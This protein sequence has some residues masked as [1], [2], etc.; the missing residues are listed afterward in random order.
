MRGETRGWT[1]SGQSERG[2]W[3]RAAGALACL[4][5]ATPLGCGDAEGSPSDVIA[6][7]VAL[8]PF[9]VR[10]PVVSDVTLR[11]ELVAELRA[12]RRAELRA[13]IAGLLEEVEV[14]EGQAVQAGQLL[15]TVNAKVLERELA[16]ARAAVQGAEAEVRAVQLEAQNTRTLQRGGV[17]SEAEVALATAKVQSARAR[18]EE[19]KAAVA[20]A[21]VTLDLAHIRAPFDGVIHRLPLRQGS[22]VAEGDLLTTLTDTREVLAYYQLPEAELL[23]TSVERAS[24][25]VGLR[26]ADGSLYPTRGSVDAIAAEVDS[27]TGT[28]TVRA[29]FANAD[30]RLRHG[31]AAKVVL[32]RPLPRALLV[33]QA[34]TFEVQGDVY[35]FIVGDDS[36]VTARKITVAH[37]VDGDY[38]VT[39]G[40]RDDER[41][42]VEGVHKLREGQRIDVTP[43]QVHGAAGATQHH[44]G[45]SAH[46]GV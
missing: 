41:F 14:D 12:G 20:L 42:V 11:R 35:V 16:V 29:R 32:D 13:R 19:A 6:S 44:Q 28:L 38:V 15:F 27:T 26:L 3:R 8:R 2:G 21:E 23:G 18:V 1:A 5:A 22:A 31:S 33:P 39:A 17:V 9:A 45:T 24:D 30:R 43:A 40:L 46:R 34:S 7:K 25:Q 4:L 37:R 10:K 36:V